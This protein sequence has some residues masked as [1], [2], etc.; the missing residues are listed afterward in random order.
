MFAIPDVLVGPDYVQYGWGNGETVRAGVYAAGSYQRVL[1]SLHI[2][3]KLECNQMPLV[4]FHWH[5]VLNHSMDQGIC[6]DEWFT[7][8][9]EGGG[10]DYEHLFSPP[11]TSRSLNRKGIIRALCRAGDSRASILWW[12]QQLTEI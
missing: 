5:M 12:F 6:N 3:L 9:L 7:M 4:G 1:Y 8:I 10:E 2:R 11:Y